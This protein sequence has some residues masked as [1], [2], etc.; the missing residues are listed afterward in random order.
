MTATSAETERPSEPAL[1]V[2]R[3]IRLRVDGMA[4]GGEGLA[5][6]PDGRVV[7]VSGAIPGDTVTAT[8]T[9]VKKRWAKAETTEVVEA[10]PDRI[11]PTCPAAA[12]GA[13]CCDLSR[14]KPE[15]QLAW[16]RDILLGQLGAL[17][18]RSGVL[19]AIDLSAVEATQL[20]PLTG[21]RSR[22]RLGVDGAG[23]AG[24]RRAR[25]SDVVSGVQCT[26]PVPGLLDGIVG[27]RA[28]TFT[29]G[30]E[31]VVV[32]D[33]NGTRHVVETQRAR[34]GRRV[35]HVE[36]VLEGPGQE[37]QRVRGFDF[38]FPP[39]AFWQAHV[40]APEAYSD[41]VEAW[42][43][44]AYVK[45][46][47]WDLYGGVGAFAPAMSAALGGGRI[48]S[49]D[50]SSAAAASQQ[51]VASALDIQMHH[52][53]VATVVGQLPPP[54]LVVMDPPR[55]GAGEAFVNAIADAGP[56]RIIH[57]GCDPATFARDL[58]GFGQRGF[59]VKQLM[60][61]DAFPNTHHFEAIAA[62]EPA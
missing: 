17:A 50:Y 34:R 52:G 2:G 46:V 41:V 58:A 44:G 60:L 12:A 8:V 48:E 49:V 61:I 23:R 30:A 37:T 10:S 53:D 39:T 45:P 15:A 25:S 31:L 6:A 4:H 38:S 62:I 29:P 57:I 28:R 16:K 32:V 18:S 7:F 13:G 33:A 51:D 56:E 59:V 35:E 1:E 36:R 14:V 43:A 5:H 9:K 26:Q 55:S 20:E 40:A 21:W 11:A 22:V 27:E 47:G 54:G 3:P 19:D 24:L 42:G